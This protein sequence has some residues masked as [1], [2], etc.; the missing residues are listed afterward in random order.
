MLVFDFNF[1]WESFYGYLASVLTA[2]CV[3]SRV[4]N[5]LENIYWLLDYDGFHVNWIILHSHCLLPFQHKAFLRFFV[6]VFGI[7]RFS[8][9]VS[10]KVSC[11]LG[12]K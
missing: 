2:N 11:D 7:E 6:F 12:G 8:W 5:G 9:L 10:N 3:S 1:N 4:W